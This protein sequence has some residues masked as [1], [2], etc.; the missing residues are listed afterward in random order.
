MYFIYRLQVIGPDHCRH[1]CFLLALEWD[2]VLYPDRRKQ[3]SSYLFAA[4]F[5]IQGILFL[6]GVPKP[7]VSYRI[8][9][10]ISSVTG[11]VLILHGMIG[12]PLVGSLVGHS[13]PQMAFV[14]LFPCPTL[15]FTFGLFLRT[16]SK[17]PRYLLVIPFLWG[18]FGVMTIS[19]CMVQDVGMLLGALLAT[20]MIVYRD[21]KAMLGTGPR[22][23]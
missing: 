17:I 16:D 2:N 11:I 7:P 22:P 5:I 1:P 14:G 3:S 8:R 4:L 19:I 15:P 12:S 6:F 23:A 13:Y 21:R 10:D 18:V 9:A 20:G